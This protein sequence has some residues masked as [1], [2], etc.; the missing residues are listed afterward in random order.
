MILSNTMQHSSQLRVKYITEKLLN[1]AEAARFLRVS[2]ASI[3]RWSDSGLLA[4]RR[5]GRRKERRFTEPDLLAFM[6]ASDS[7]QRGATGI[8]VGGESVPVPCHLATFFSSD[9]GGLRLTVPFLAEGLRLGQACFLV[10]TDPVLKRYID[11]LGEQKGVDVTGATQDGRLTLVR[12]EQATGPSTIEQW[13]RRFA[14]VLAKG[15]TIIRLVGEMERVRTMFVS[16]A[17]MLSY[18]EAFEM[19][20]RRYPIVAICQYDVRGFDGEALLRS[21]KSHPD[22]FGY[23]IGTFLN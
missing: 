16:E 15:P 10:A 21:L 19:M 11:A 1:T 13:E 3:R 12:F 6:K 20:S 7:P 5:V 14:D 18:E 4:A 17:E 23:R 9:A 8:N 2:Q 22:L